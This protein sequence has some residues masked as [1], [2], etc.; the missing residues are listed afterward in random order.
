MVTHDM[1][2]A[3]YFADNLVL[4]NSGKLVQHGSY[5]EFIKHPN[6]KFV[7]DFIHAQYEPLKQFLLYEVD[8]Q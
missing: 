6:N 7:T 2:E 8:N 1:S 5:S 3:V 4:I